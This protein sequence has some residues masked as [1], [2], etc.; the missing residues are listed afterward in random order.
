MSSNSK[1]DIFG[2][3]GRKRIKQLIESFSKKI[4]SVGSLEQEPEIIR[5]A[6]DREEEKDSV[7]TDIQDNSEFQKLMF[8]NAKEKNN[9]F[10]VAEKKKW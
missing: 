10:I 8:K 3:E 4:S 6:C 1:Q 7:K 2:E 9:D 5:G